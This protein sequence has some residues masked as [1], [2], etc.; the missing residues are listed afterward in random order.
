MTAA[1]PYYDADAVM[2]LGYAG[3]VDAIVSALRGGLDPAAGV[4]RSGVDL[5]H[6]QLLL[7]PAETAT[8]T[9]IKLV[10]VA[11]GN[12]ER[13]VPTVH[14]TYL[15][16]DRTTLAPAAILDGTA[17]TTLRTPAV[18]LAAVL[19]RLPERPLRLVVIGHGPQARGHAAAFAAVRTLESTAYLVRDPDRSPVPATALGTAAARNTLL[20]ADVIVCA[21]SARTPVL[22]NDDV[23]DDAV[24]AAVGAYEPDARELDGAL[25]ARSTVVVEDLATALGENGDVVLAIAEGMLTT[26][27]VVTMRDV[28]A[29]AV[30]PAADRPLVFTGVGM[31]WQDLVVAGAVVA[32]R[33]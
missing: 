26:R 18:S 3:A 33:Q 15:L 13:G 6:G 25:L 21:T 9:G 27:D 11:P 20:A 7:M 29:G 4:P 2:A 24:V 28:V 14:A 17:L 30:Q 32:V 23:S 31:A 19:H 1:L 8:A 22:H 5:A 16:L 12:A 10:T